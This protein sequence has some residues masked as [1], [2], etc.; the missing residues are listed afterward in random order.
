MSHQ[1][2]KANVVFSHFKEALLGEI[3]EYPGLL[4]TAQLAA[5]F[6]PSLGAGPRES[7]GIKAPRTWPHPPIVQGGFS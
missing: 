4:A 5:I 6:S 1:T 7:E 3:P 2:K